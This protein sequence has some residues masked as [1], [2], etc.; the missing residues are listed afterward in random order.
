MINKP[1]TE[2]EPE[3]ATTLPDTPTEALGTM[4]NPK[5][6][7]IRYETN[8]SIEIS[9]DMEKEVKPTGVEIE[10]EP[11]A[12]ETEDTIKDRTPPTPPKQPTTHNRGETSEAL[13]LMHKNLQTKRESL[14]IRLTNV[15]HWLETNTSS[16]PS[17]LFQDLVMN[18]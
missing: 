14:N 2:P 6:A 1:G 10:E 15:K 13:M 4:G 5:D 17:T 9:S 11:R 8:S 7:L 3:E 18:R 16:E 12:G